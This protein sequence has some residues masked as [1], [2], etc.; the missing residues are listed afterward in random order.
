MPIPN[1]LVT[2]ISISALVI[3]IFLIFFS[4]CILP[5]YIEN[6]MNYEPSNG[7]GAVTCASTCSIDMQKRPWPIIDGR[8]PVAGDRVLLKNQKNRTENGIWIV[9]DRFD[10]E[11][12]RSRDL[13]KSDQFKDGIMV[14]VLGGKKNRD[15]TFVLRVMNRRKRKV[16]KLDISFISAHDHMMIPDEDEQKYQHI[17][18][19]KPRDIPTVIHI[20]SSVPNDLVTSWKHSNTDFTLQ[21]WDEQQRDA[22]MA[23]VFDGKYREWYKHLRP[24]MRE[25][26]I[27]WFI[28]YQYGGLFVADDATPQN[29]EEDHQVGMTMYVDSMI[30]ENEA[31]MINDRTNI[32]IKHGERVGTIVLSSVEH[33]PFIHFV[34]IH[35]VNTYSKKCEPNYND[36]LTVIYQQ[37][38]GDFH[39]IRLI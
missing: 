8:N 39:D 38:G 35:M 11:W 13:R 19:T 18:T 1:T 24:E 27:R 34:V 12:S 2:V 22:L 17:P 3:S 16:G 4:I 5:V 32:G 25:Y 21:I 31:T 7:L 28:L 15:R 37:F 6:S 23:T 30:S 20:L 14:L 10:K 9:P 26:V 36:D 29:V 33:H